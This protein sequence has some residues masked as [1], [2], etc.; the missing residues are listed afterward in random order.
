MPVRGGKYINEYNEDFVG[1]VY[2]ANSDYTSASF[3]VSEEGDETYTVTV[4]GK[5]DSTADAK[6]EVYIDGVLMET[7]TFNSPQTTE[8]SFEIVM[9]NNT[10]HK[11]KLNLIGDVS[12]SDLFIDKV[13]IEVNRPEITF[14]SPI[15]GTKVEATKEFEVSWSCTSTDNGTYSLFWVDAKSGEAQLLK[16]D[17]KSTDSFKT[18]IPNWFTGA[19]G[20]YTLNKQNTAQTER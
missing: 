8:K 5:S 16:E 9:N 12:E 4:V 1:M 19:E 13:R 15:S 18:E 17:L 10:V 14:I 6:I 11:I 7:L 2:Y 3:T 20:Y